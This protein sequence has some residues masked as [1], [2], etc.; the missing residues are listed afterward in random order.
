MLSSCAVQLMSYCAASGLL[1]SC[2]PAQ[3]Q[4]WLAAWMGGSVWAAVLFSCR[5]VELPQLAAWLPSCARLLCCR[6]IQLLGKLLCCWSPW[7]LSYWTVDL[8]CWYAFGMFNCSSCCAVVLL[9]CCAADL[10]SCWN[11]ELLYCLIAGQLTSW[12]PQLRQLWTSEC[13]V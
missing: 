11:V 12:L 7:V 3:Q 4:C 5:A 2:R 9:D 10:L 1:Q 8:L 6:P 13:R